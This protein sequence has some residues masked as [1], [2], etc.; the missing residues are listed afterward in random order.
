MAN[1]IKAEFQDAGGNIYHLHTSADVVFLED[2][3]TL[4][5]KLGTLVDSSDGDISATKISTVD[6]VSTGFPVPAA[7]ESTKTFAG[8]VKKFFQ[9]F[10]TLKDTLLTLSKLV[11][12][13][14]TTATGFALD[15]RYGKTLY[16]LY[17]QLNSNLTTT[18]NNLT[19]L[20]NK[21]PSD[22]NYINSLPPRINDF[23]GPS[24]ANLLNDITYIINAKG[25]LTGGFGY[26]DV[27]YSDKPT[28]TIGW[29]YVEFFKHADNNV[30]VKIYP[31]E[32]LNFY[33]CRFTL[34]QSTWASAWQKVQYTV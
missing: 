31:E 18:S 20:K 30:T 22:L 14:Q 34:G 7:G 11:N 27:T 6:T 13:G 26:A 33:V 1:K 8:K 24:S 9:D 25:I 5:S 15:A 12:N 19:A 3:S 4:E 16:D 28:G 10:V 29:G 21:T 23:I 2:G 17:A 32:S